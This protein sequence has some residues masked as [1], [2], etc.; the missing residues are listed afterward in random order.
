MVALLPNIDFRLFQA[1]HVYLLASVQGYHDNFRPVKQSLRE[2]AVAEPPADHENRRAFSINA[3]GVA[4]K[5][6]LPWGNQATDKRQPNLS[7]VG[8]SREN[9]IDPQMAVSF[10]KFR[11]VG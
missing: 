11:P 1:H 9:Q 3:A 10:N 5:E 6:A 4:R 7:A 8:V 2:N